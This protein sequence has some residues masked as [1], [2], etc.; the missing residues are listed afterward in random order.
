MV[1]GLNMYKTL[2]RLSLEKQSKYA[3]QSD[4]VKFIDYLVHLLLQLVGRQRSFLQHPHPQTL[5]P[6]SSFPESPIPLN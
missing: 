3:S 1:R 4:P 2:M 5:C 6:M